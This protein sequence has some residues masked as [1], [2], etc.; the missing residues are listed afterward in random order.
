L[1]FLSAAE[2]ILKQKDTLEEDT[3]LMDSILDVVAWTHANAKGKV[4]EH[5]NCGPQLAAS[6]CTSL[7]LIKERSEELSTKLIDK[8]FERVNTP[9]WLLYHAST[10]NQDV[11]IRFRDVLVAAVGRTEVQRAQRIISE[12]EKAGEGLVGYEHASLA[13]H[14][15]HRK[16]MI[17][18]I[19]KFSSETIDKGSDAVEAAKLLPPRTRSS[20]RLTTKTVFAWICE[21]KML[22][23]TSLPCFPQTQCCVDL[24]QRRVVQHGMVRTQL[25]LCWC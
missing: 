11:K 21:V 2:Q 19:K 16:M 10:K 15:P 6:L 4:K 13:H 17:R 24:E 3:R 22:S 25:L 9:D 7:M 12:R 23:S 18:M 8:M 20:S 5:N 1:A 14:K